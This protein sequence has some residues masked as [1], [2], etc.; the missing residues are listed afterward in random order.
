MTARVYTP[1]GYA[2]MVW[3]FLA[4][5]PRCNLWAGMGLGK[6]SLVLILLEI[7][8]NLIGEDGPTLVLA[9]LRVAVNTWPRETAK[10]LRLAGLTVVSVTG[11]ADER[12]AALRTPA[13]V[14]V[15]NYD[16]L[17]WLSEYFS[18]A[19]KPWPF[20]RV[21]ADESP[22]LKGFRTKQGGVRAQV[23]GRIAH[24][25]VEGWIN[26]T[27]TPSSNGLA[28]LWGQQWF[29]DQGKRLGR[30]YTAYMENYFIPIVNDGYTNWVIRE[31]SQARIMAALADC[32]LTVDASD[33]FDLDKPITNVIKV[34]MPARA[35]VHYKALEKEFFT[36]IGGHQIEAFSA[37]AK[38]MKLLQCASGALYLGA[39]RYGPDA[40]IE[41]HDAKLEALE[42]IVEEA[43]GAPILV[44][45]HFRSDLARLQKAFPKGRV[46]DADP[47][48]LVD[49]DAGRIPLLFA[50]PGS[51]G[52]GL[53]LQDGGNILVFFSQWWDLEQHDQIIE[54][55]GP[56]RQL[57]AGHPRAVFVHYLL[58][59]NTVDEVVM[60]RRTSKRAV[61]DLLLDYMKRK[62]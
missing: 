32:S 54:R 28:D 41:V 1:R 61:Q 36:E 22:R 31:S 9:P 48:T 59:A 21:V 12:R 13:Q 4:R 20:K 39:K 53:D 25:E 30:S 10:W 37:A 35:R 5:H 57:Q 29:V 3:D 7:L 51:A 58:A 33:W 46:L 45:Y 23:L 8:H 55:I 2:P 6:T 52:H 14:Y 60:E 19:K 24:T 26:L 49:W 17:V 16:N 47:R 40:A 38:S 62:K 43:Q 15:I 27:G 50:H 42:S 11:T 44:A 18:D 34:E 56:T